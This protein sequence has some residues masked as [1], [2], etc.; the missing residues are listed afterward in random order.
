MPRHGLLVSEAPHTPVLEQSQIIHVKILFGQ[1]YLILH[2]TS[3]EQSSQDH[4]PFLAPR[5]IPTMKLRLACPYTDFF[6]L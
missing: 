3:A 6:C 1:R 5:T 4:V 2:Q